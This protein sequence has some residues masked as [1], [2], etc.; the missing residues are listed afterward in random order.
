MS[1]P[2]KM[3]L[4]LAANKAGRT[5]NPNPYGL[6]AVGVIPAHVAA[7]ERAEEEEIL[8]APKKVIF[9]SRVDAMDHEFR[10]CEVL[11]SISDTKTAAPAFKHPPQ[12]MLELHF[13]DHVTYV[14]EGLGLRWM[15]MEDGVKI[16]E[17]VAKH[18]DK[19]NIIVHCNYGESRSKAVAMAIA[20]YTDRR[21]LRVNSFG[22]TQAYRENHDKG[23]SR[24]YTITSDALLYHSEMEAA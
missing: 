6:R 13:N 15:M 8:K 2:S 9:M 16:A 5:P 12:D 4:R 24:V 17:F 11:I 18:T 1:K 22:R 20:A 14:D 23:N 10:D 3:Q 7:K 21:V 19:R